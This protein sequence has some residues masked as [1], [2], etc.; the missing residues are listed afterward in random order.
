MAHFVRELIR[1]LRDILNLRVQVD[2]M[3]ASKTAGTLL[4]V[5]QTHTQRKHLS[6]RHIH[7]KKA[8]NLVQYDKKIISL[9]RVIFRIQIASGMFG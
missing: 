2:F 6:R 1:C 8:D 7:V 3:A 4:A 5:N 9:A